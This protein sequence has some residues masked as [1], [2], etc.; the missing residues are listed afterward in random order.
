M[1]IDIIPLPS[2][3]AAAY[4]IT[5][6]QRVVVSTGLISA[7]DRVILCEHGAPITLT[8][9]AAA[10]VDSLF[11]IKDRLG[12]AGSF[13]ITID[14]PGPELIDGL[15]AYILNTAYRSVMIGREAGGDFFI[16]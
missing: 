9:P 15:G 1:S 12:V 6:P 14:T 3:G 5:T 4:S 7:A 10:T 16:F 13:P 8:L 11:I 2:D